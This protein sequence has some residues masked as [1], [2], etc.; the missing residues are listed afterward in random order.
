[1]CVFYNF[2]NKSYIY[3]LEFVIN[4]WEVTPERLSHVENM[5]FV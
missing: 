2:F 4:F 3:M 5:G 1:V